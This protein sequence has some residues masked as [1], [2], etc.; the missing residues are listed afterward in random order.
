MPMLRLPSRVFHRV[1][2]ACALA[3]LASCGSRKEGALRFDIE[4][5][6]RLRA[7]CVAFVGTSNG[8]RVISG[9]LVRTPGKHQ[10][11]AGVARASLPAT[12][13]WQAT[14]VTGS[15]G[16]DVTWK[17]TSVSEPKTV[18]FPDGDVQ[19]HPLRLDLPG[20]DLDADR[21]TYVDLGQRGDDCNDGDAAVNPGATQVCGSTVDTNCDAK[22]FCDDASCAGQAACQR[23]A[24]RLSVPMPPTTVVNHE[25][26][27]EVQLVTT[28]DQNQATP[29]ARPTPITLSGPTGLEFFTD[30]TCTTPVA[31]GVLTLGFGQSTTS[32]WFRARVAGV[33]MVQARTSALG[34]TGFSVTVTEQPIAEVRATPSTLTV[35]SGDCSQPIELSAF[36]AQGRPTNATRAVDLTGTIEPAGTTGVAYFTDATCSMQGEGTPRFAAGTSTTLVR[37]RA[38]QATA[39]GMPLEVRF[40]GVGITTPARVAVTVTAGAPARV[41][42]REQGVSVERAMCS[43]QDVELRLFD[44][45]GNRT[46]A[47]AGGAV[48]SLS[49]VPPAGG[50]PLQFFTA[51]LCAS[52]PVTTTVTIPAGQDA[53]RLLLNASTNGRY[54]VTASFNGMNAP[55][56]EV[57][58]AANPPSALVFPNQAATLTASAGTG[59]RAVRVQTRETSSPASALSGVRTTTV[60]NVAANPAGRA[61]F[62]SDPACAMSLSQLTFGVGASE[63]TFYFRGRLAGPF[64]IEATRVSGDTL[65]AASPSQPAAIDPGPTSRLEFTT[66]LAVAVEANACTPAFGLLARDAFD[67]PTRANFQVSPSAAPAL[68]D[69]GVVFYSAAGCATAASAIDVVDGGATFFAQARVARA[70]AI[71]AQSSAPSAV[72]QLPDGGS[73][74][75]T[76]TVGPAAAS[77]LVVTTQPPATLQAGACQSVTIERRDAFGNPVTG[78]AQGFSASASASTVLSVHGD[79]ASCTAGTAGAPLQ[80]AAGASTATFFVRGRLVG[81]STVTVTGMGSATTSQVMV[82]P[83]DAAQLEFNGLSPTSTVGTCATATVRRRDAEGNLTTLPAGFMA[84]VTASGATSNLR[85]GTSCPTPTMGTS[86]AVA[87]ASANSATFAYEPRALGTLTFTATATGVPPPAA[88]ASTTVGVGAVASVNF[89]TPPTGPQL[90]AAC[91][92]LEVEALDA[93]GNRVAASVTLANS[94]GGSFYPSMTCTGGTITSG[95]VPAG[96]TFS[97]FYSPTATGMH[98]VSA[99]PAGPVGPGT[100]T[101]QVNPGTPTT[102]TRTPAFMTN[103]PSGTCVTFT[104]E[105]IDG[106]GNPTT[107]GGPLAVSA[108]L[109]GSAAASAQ[110]FSDA[111][112]VTAGMP[113]IAAGAA[114]AQFSVRPQ[115]VGPLT[116][117][118]SSSL[119]TN[120]GNTSTTVVPGPLSGIVFTTMAPQPSVVVG[121]CTLVTV[122]GRDAAMNPAPLDATIT[123]AMMSATFHRVAGCGDAPTTTIAGSTATS[124]NFYVRPTAAATNV[125]LTVTTAPSLSIMQ[126]WSFALPAATALRFKAPAPGSVARL[127]CVGPYR[128]E[129]TDGTNAVPSGSNRV[130]T[131]GGTSVQWFSDPGCATPITTVD[132]LTAQ[133]ETNEF[134]FVV[135]GNAASVTLTGTAAPALTGASANVT[136]TGNPGP[137]TLNVSATSPELEFRACTALTL[138]RRV[139]G[140]AFSGGNFPTV[141]SLSKMGPGVG[142][143]TLHA[144]ND[145][146]GVELTSATIPANQSS[147]TVYVAGRSAERQGAGPAFTVATATAS[148]ADQFASGFGSGSQVFNVHPAVRRGSCTIAN[149]QTSSTA[150][151]STACT[152]SPPLPATPGVRERT[153]FTFQTTLPNL[154]GASVQNTT[155]ELNGGATALECSRQAFSNNTL[156]IEWQ[157]VSLASGMSVRHVKQSIGSTMPRTVQT[158]LGADLPADS[159]FLLVSHKNSSTAL[160]WDDFPVSELVGTMAG[161]VSTLETR[162]GGFNYELPFELNAQVVT[163]TGLSVVSGIVTGGAGASFTGTAPASSGTEALLYTTRISASGSA[164]ICRHRLRGTVVAG[165][166][167]FSRGAGAMGACTDVAMAET[168]WSRLSFPSAI[169]AVSA[170]ASAISIPNGQSNG[171]W[172]VGRPLPLDRTW[173]FLGGQG[174]GGQSGGESSRG[175][176]SDDDLG[177]L[178]A[179]VS[180]GTD[181]MGNTL[182]T[183]TR[184][185]STSN[186]FFSPFAVVLTP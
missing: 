52:A 55:P 56:L 44:A 111:T 20:A 98:T 122:E 27:P 167:T 151:Q 181:G 45:L 156:N 16:D 127:Q 165:V 143:A 13:T 172:A 86:Q 107:L 135:F 42:F 148:A 84:T 134:Y 34:M 65:S 163:W 72:T 103:T 88:T 14:A 150:T 182:V 154:G 40:G 46:V 168:V 41:E 11:T 21:D 129:S 22:L 145:C 178:A 170:P 119:T 105:R 43:T 30:A 76:L 141:L 69:G 179:R 102:L 114:S 63:Q 3:G 62:F 117:A 1:L 5:D 87:F 180:Y 36:D 133:T 79:N 169:A 50:G 15:C 118:L 177:T 61:G 158:P 37:L 104:L 25:C 51:P 89:V 39:A 78:A 128:F 28:D 162:N 176:G 142:G 75:V 6:S 77:V 113:S 18:S 125:S 139:N 184:G 106:A 147:V 97:F 109:S 160:D 66:P 47:G 2:F 17:V 121:S 57:S 35:A 81:T 12:L 115:L 138:E 7:D 144:A 8:S 80:F 96:G 159:T 10:Y 171:S 110:V 9:F 53:L 157:V 26:S 58:V 130:I 123:L 155:C 64:F 91:I 124:V 136:V 95:M 101:F 19:A 33:A 112:C 74:A 116:L 67:N 24:T 4:L 132:L 175:G 23:S 73:A 59:C 60:V 183:L 174:P 140:T 32:F 186:S 38:T 83:G 149:N 82:T 99:D 29:V 68:T 161:T 71:N 70:Y 185:S 152:I 166:P 164:A 54:T 100:A 173:V 153:F 131:F 85:L 93:G 92:P 90:A 48:V 108:T 31:G 49:V 94:L 137:L 146:T 126:S 120:P